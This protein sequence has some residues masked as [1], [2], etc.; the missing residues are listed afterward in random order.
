MLWQPN[1]Y[2]TKQ[3]GLSVITIVR[4]CEQSAHMIKFHAM[5][6]DVMKKC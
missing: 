3:R 1:F 5:D 4:T 6:G 2:V